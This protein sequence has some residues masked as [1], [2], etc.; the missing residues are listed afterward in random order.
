MFENLVSNK[1]L[2]I[3]LI[4]ALIILLYFYSRKNS[5]DAN[6]KNIEPMQNVDLTP[7]AQNLV[8]GPWAEEDEQDFKNVNN[9]FD[10]KADCVV[11]GR[12][13]NANFLKRKDQIYKDY[14]SLDGFD[15]YFDPNFNNYAPANFDSYASANFGIYDP[16]RY[17]NYY[18]KQ[19]RR[20]IASAGSEIDSEYDDDYADVDADEDELLTYTRA[21]SRPAPALARANS[22]AHTYRRKLRRSRKTCP[23]CP[24]C[25]PC[26]RTNN[27]AGTGAGAGAVIQHR[28]G[29]GITQ[30][31]NITSSDDS[32]DVHATAVL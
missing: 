22:R 16:N 28:N 21:R 5:C 26:A 31:A 32:D 17:Y 19:Q 6:L 25:P 10:K 24:P 8:E 7:L 29:P 14:A 27:G 18:T 13:K 12:I 3:A 23:P 2:V 15:G 20:R 4:I 9:A 30:G 1:Y 11:R